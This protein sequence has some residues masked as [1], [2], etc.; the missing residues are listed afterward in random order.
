MA[1]DTNP[2]DP[3]GTDPAGT[4]PTTSG[5]TSSDLTSK[6][7]AAGPA[8]PWWV[9]AV[10]A[11]VVAAGVVARFLPRGSMWLDEAL[12]ANIAQLPLGDIRGA[13]KRD[14][15][16]P[17]YYVL[18]HAWG[19]VVGWSPWA[20]RALSGILGVAALPL[21][22]WAGLRVGGRPDADGVRDPVRA[23]RTATAALVLLA[24]LPFAIRYSSETRMYS[25]VMLLV[26][27][28]YLL[29]DHHRERPRWSTAVG[30][31]VVAGLLLWTHYWSIWLLGSLG[32]VL[33]VQAVVEHRRGDTGRR[34]A[35][36]GLAAAIVAGTLTFLP[37]LPTMLYQSAHTGTPWGDVVRP[38]AFGVLGMIQVFGG[39]VAEPQLT[40]YVVAGLMA[41]GLFGVTNAAGRVEL[42]WRVRPTA[43]RE[44]LVVVVTLGV[45]WAAS[46]AARSAFSARYL[47]VVVPLIVLL[48]A[49]G[50]TAIGNDAWRRIVALV[51]I[52]GFATGVL[53]EIGR[54]R[55]QAGEVGD[56]VVSV[57]EAAPADSPEPLVVTCPDQNGPSVQRALRDRGV[58]DR[59]DVVAVPRLDDPRFVDWVDYEDRNAAIDPAEVAGR[60]TERADGRTLLY[61]V[62][63]GY[64]TLEGKCEGIQTALI[65]ARGAPRVLVSPDDRNEDEPG[66]LLLEFPAP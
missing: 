21:A 13:L 56:A 24:A 63:E 20:L 57:L 40:A 12:S 51:V 2:T 64:K 10:V 52:A 39:A 14:G 18:L 19:A 36:L 44:G 8:T 43:R 16:P 11:L 38:A 46:F 33:L 26:L 54:I 34:N 29:V 28:G 27:V 22:W 15:H 25:L 55:T 41:L 1:D 30:T 58:E 65:Q 23:R 35:E 4:D 45:A 32:L 5:P 62:T 50:L 59:V 7:A 37:W 49:M 6:S 42:G 17:L 48:V 66:I 3:A 47:A 31:A 61:A 60:I 9:T 53:V